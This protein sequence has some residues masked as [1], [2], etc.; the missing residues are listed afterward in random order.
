VATEDRGTRRE[1][2]ARESTA[3]EAP[4]AQAAPVVADAP[5]TPRA[6]APTKEAAPES[7]PI[8]IVQIRS[9]PGHAATFVTDQGD[10]WVETD[11]P[12][13]QYPQ[14]PFKASIEPGAMSSFFLV[15]ENRGRAI[16]VRRQ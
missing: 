6:A 12:R 15:P 4:A 8:V 14:T 13:S 3:S 7:V 5:R 11:K 9:L 16:R 2:R 10:V 1:R